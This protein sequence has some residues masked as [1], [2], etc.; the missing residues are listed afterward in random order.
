MNVI[1]EINRKMKKKKI[2][3]NGQQQVKEELK[4]IIKK[5]GGKMKK[6]WGVKVEE[7]KRGIKNGVRKI[8]IDKDKRMEMKGKIRRILKEEKRELDKRK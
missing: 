8:K 1:E 5:Y 7:I 6:K 4:E 3:M 2:V